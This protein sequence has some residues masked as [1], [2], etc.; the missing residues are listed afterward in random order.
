MKAHFSLL[1]SI[2][3]AKEREVFQQLDSMLENQYKV[4]N[5][6][7]KGLSHCHM[8]LVNKMDKI[9]L[10]NENSDAITQDIFKTCQISSYLKCFLDDSMMTM[11]K[12]E[13]KTD[14]NPNPDFLANLNSLLTSVISF[15]VDDQQ[16]SYWTGLENTIHELTVQ[17]TQHV[18][19]IK[20]D[21]ETPAFIPVADSSSPTP[22][23]LDTES[24]AVHIE[25]N[26]RSTLRKIALQTHKVGNKLTGFIS[27]NESPQ[28]FYVQVSN[29]HFQKLHL[30][31]Q[32]Q[33]SELTEPNFQTEI[34]LH[35]NH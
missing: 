31:L 11:E 8:Q 28:S 33:E 35:L 17:L 22:S 9:Q 13:P 21:P 3:Q 26:D 29:D 20:L 27:Y 1:H 14:I 2:L 19:V 10:I 7:R 6:A 15:L 16:S 32:N 25:T 5:D 34:G 18:K 12:I 4:L 30:S 23:V 24:D